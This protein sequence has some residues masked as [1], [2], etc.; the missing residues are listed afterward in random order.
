[1]N[2]NYLKKENNN[3]SI[4]RKKTFKEMFVIST[5]YVEESKFFA[6]KM[7]FGKKG[8][9]REYRSGGQHIRNESEIFEN[10]LIGKLAEFSFYQ[11]L[12]DNS[13]F[14]NEPDITTYKKGK[15]DNCDFLVNSMKINVKSTK[16]FGNLML[17]ETKDWN[18]KAEYIPN[19]DKGEQNYDFFVFIRIKENDNQFV[20]D[21]PGY[22]LHKDLIYIIE[23]KYILPQ[24]SFLNGKIKM[25]AENYY[26]QS[27]DMKNINEL[28]TL[29]KQ[30]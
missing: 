23:N 6:H 24:K 14:T 4:N 11:F 2:F 1:M 9:H 19:I 28:T 21:I 3:Y 17:L 12:N 22:I 18:S 29:L 13:I 27:G 30:S 16:F 26:I 25:D 20:C 8:E 15:W 5:K 7:T 10:A